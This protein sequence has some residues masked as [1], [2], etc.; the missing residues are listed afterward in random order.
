MQINT[1]TT[2]MEAG[3]TLA[4]DKD[5]RDHCVVVVK[6]TFVLDSL[7]HPRPGEEQ[8]PLIAADV[9]HGDP[10]STSIKYECEFAMVK[11]RVDVIVN[12]DAVAPGNKPVRDLMVELQFGS[13]RKEIRV[14]G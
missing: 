3:L 8:E 10:G 14:I 2:G 11:P 9:H 5:G 6:G 4:T 13:I 12:G 7:G 1:N